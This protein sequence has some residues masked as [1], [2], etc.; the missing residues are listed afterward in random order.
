[1]SD[2]IPRDYL[3]ERELIESLAFRNLT[4]KNTAK[5]VALKAFAA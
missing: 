2:V 3:T 4:S 1:M 5:N